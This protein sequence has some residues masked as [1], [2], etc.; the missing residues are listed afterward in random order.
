MTP[1]QWWIQPRCWCTAAC[2]VRVFTMDSAVLGL[3]SWGCDC[4]TVRDFRQKFTREDAIGLH[5]VAPLEALACVYHACDQCH[6]SRVSTFLPGNCKLRPHTQGRDCTCWMLPSCTVR[7]FNHG[8]CC[9]RVR[10]FGP[11]PPCTVRVFRQDLHSRM[12]LD[13]TH[14]SRESTALTVAIINHVETLEGPR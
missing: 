10:T 6:S 1:W 12:P 3:A 14:S 13:P 11:A 2:A 4:C 9:V 5:A 8:F 7:V